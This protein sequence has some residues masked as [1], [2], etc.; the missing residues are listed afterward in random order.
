MKKVDLHIHSNYS[1]GSDSVEDLAEIVVSNNID[2]FALTDHDT[3]EG[4]KEIIKYIPT[5]IKFIPSIELT[6]IAD[7]IKCH[8]LGYNC[9]PFNEYLM[10][11]IEKGKVLRKNKL[12]TR[13]KYLK[14]VW[15]IELTN[16]E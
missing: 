5:N 8:I 12:K 1:D 2:I 13:I 15:N 7:D 14:D 10:N 16:D 9:N 3:N 4:C 6:C 11:L